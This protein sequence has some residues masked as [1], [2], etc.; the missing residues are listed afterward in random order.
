MDLYL[1][2]TKIKNIYKKNCEKSETS[3]S[4]RINPLLGNRFIV[5]NSFLK[6]RQELRQ[7]AESSAR[8]RICCL[9]KNETKCENAGFALYA[10]MKDVLFLIFM[11]LSLYIISTAIQNLSFNTP[12]DL[13]MHT[14]PLSCKIPIFSTNIF[15]MPSY[16][17]LNN[18]IFLFMY[19]QQSI[20]CFIINSYSIYIE[21]ERLLYYVR[22]L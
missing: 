20:I 1:V 7:S 17:T 13:T 14:N 8:H 3:E 18:H 5:S 6:V 19:C 9:T 21:K 15:T 10:S 2:H 16:G 22:L 11:T 12:Y 4:K